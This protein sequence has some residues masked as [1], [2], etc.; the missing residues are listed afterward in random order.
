MTVNEVDPDTED[1]DHLSDAGNSKAE[2]RQ[3][4]QDADLDYILAKPRGRRW[5]Y[6]LTHEDCHVD[7]LSL[8]TGDQE[9]TAFNEGARAIGLALLEDVKAKDPRLYMQ[10]LEE[11]L[12]P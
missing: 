4:D 5:L 10:M 7:R 6:H 9:A 11:N 12:I 3:D 1:F 8:V 2:K